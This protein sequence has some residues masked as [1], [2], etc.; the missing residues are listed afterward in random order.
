[1][2]SILVVTLTCADRPGIVDEIT[3]VISAHAANWE[4]SRMAHLGGEFA[5]I[6][7]ISVPAER[8]DALTAALRALES[9]G[10]AV[11]VKATQAPPVETSE[12]HAI[13]EIQLT[14]ADHE[15]IVHA[16]SHFLASQGINVEAMETQ[17]VPAPITATPLFQMHAQIK[18]PQRLSQGEL[19]SGLDHLAHELGVDIEVRPTAN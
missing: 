16:V 15:G 13:C 1:M 2:K 19:S 3:E 5:G 8:A 11:V 17:V 18:V 9:N 12:G 14:G 4:E 6:V 10:I 7:K